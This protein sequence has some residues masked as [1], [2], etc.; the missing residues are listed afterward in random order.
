MS[1]EFEFEKILRQYPSPVKS[2]NDESLFRPSPFFPTTIES[3]TVKTDQPFT[4][5]YLKQTDQIPMPCF[6]PTPKYFS[7]PADIGLKEKENPKLREE[8]FQTEN[9][10]QKEDTISAGYENAFVN[11]NTAFQ[12][13]CH[14]EDEKLVECEEGVC[15]IVCEEEKKEEVPK[16]YMTRMEMEQNIKNLLLKV[17]NMELLEDYIKQV[18]RKV[19]QIR[20]ILCLNEPPK[21]EEIVEENEFN[22]MEKET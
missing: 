22:E 3:S 1:S 17:E 4:P 11:E 16:H 9:A 15:R 7:Y 20:E 2:T 8:F 12:V 21:L 19:E 6:L 10:F 5:I 14:Q 13:P 18:E